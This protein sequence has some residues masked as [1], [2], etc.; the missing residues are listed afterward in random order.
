MELG[1]IIGLP[2]GISMILLGMIIEGGHLSSIV[3]LPAFLIVVG[4][5]VGAT[6]LNTPFPT[7]KQALKTLI[8]CF[9]KK[10][11]NCES[12]VKE[13]VRLS[14]ISRKDGLLALEKERANISDPLFSEGLKFA[15]DGLE[16]N[17]VASILESRINFKM[18]ENMRAA[19]VWSHLS[20]Y[21][22]TVGI[23]G[24]VLGLIHVMENLSNFEALGA[25]IATAFIATVYG[26]GFAYLVC[27]PIG[28]KLKA[29]TLEES[30]YYEMIKV[31]IKEI[32]QG[33]SPRIIS[34]HLMAIIDKES[35]EE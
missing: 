21:S 4:G 6:M 11:K 17:V 1:S 16:P 35:K 20:H 23:L 31:G 15:I 30:P 12:L 10:N 32:Q 34:A 9:F 26:V 24:A 3:G 14:N 29:L 19:N 27:M 22:P 8:Q 7:L 13:I 33:T 25:G 18:E 2:L 28:N 5:T